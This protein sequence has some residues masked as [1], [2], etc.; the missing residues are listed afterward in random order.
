VSLRLLA[1][2]L[3]LVVVGCQ[4]ASTL[5]VLYKAP[6]FNLTDQSGRP[7]ASTELSG[8]VVLYGFVF[9]T[10]TDICP[11]LTANM[12]QVRDG[13]R[14]AGLLPAKAALVSI[15]VDPEEDTPAAL[16]TYAERFGAEPASWRFLTGDR[17]TIMD[18]MTLGF[19]LAP[20]GAATRTPAGARDIPHVRRFVVVD[21]RGEIRWIPLGDETP[22]AQ[23]VEE[24]RRLAR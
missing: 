13:L 23:I 17:Q 3:A 19:K 11:T 21:P 20:P 8:K 6:S 12:A 2:L 24:M 4:P 5:P 14:S 22:P 1:G 16:A 10:C 15:S 7:F 18:A 9:T